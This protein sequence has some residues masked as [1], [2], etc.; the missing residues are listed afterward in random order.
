M[1]MT[2]DL[3]YRLERLA[4]ATPN[5]EPNPQFTMRELIAIARHVME[6]EKESDELA[7]L[8]ESLKNEDHG[9][10]REN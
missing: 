1:I 7:E 8:R 3:H 2:I 9:D 10:A 4:Q 5:T 6:L